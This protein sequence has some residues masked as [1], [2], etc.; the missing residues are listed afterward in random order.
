MKKR[1]F[2]LIELMIVIA[3]IGLLAAI[4]LPRF[5]GVSD[6]AKVA[7]VQGNL[8]NL[9]TSITMFY[10]KVGAYPPFPS[11]ED[12]PLDTVQGGDSKFTDFYSKGILPKTP[13][14][15]GGGITINNSNKVY[16]ASGGNQGLQHEGGWNYDVTN[17]DIHA[18]LKRGAYSDS[19]I[20]W[21]EY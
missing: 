13:A 12:L 1:G 8:A 2:T 14:F 6:S 17:G 19:S 10:I 9:R 7:Q 20:D 4:A 5:T 11:Q 18:A 21:S 3:I 15:V 16:D